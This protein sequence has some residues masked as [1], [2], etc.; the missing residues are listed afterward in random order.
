MSD[1]ENT[2]KERGAQYGTLMENG[3]ISQLLKEVMHNAKQWGKLD[4]DQK[5]AFDMIASKISRLLTGNPNHVDG[6]VDIAGYATLV[7]NRIER[8]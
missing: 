6:Y 5:E 2:L 1:L 4:P 3:L 8:I 7:A